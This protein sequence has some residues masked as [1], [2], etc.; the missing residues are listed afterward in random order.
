MITTKHPRAT[1]DTDHTVPKTRRAA[2]IECF[3]G[4][5][6]LTL[7]SVPVPEPGPGEVLIAGDTAGVGGWDADMRAGWSPGK[8]PSFPLILDSDG[9]GHV[10]AVGSRVRRFQI[11]DAVYAYSFDN[12]KGGFYAEYVAVVSSNV[13][14]GAAI[15][16]PARS[17]SDPDHRAHSYR[18][19]MMR[20]S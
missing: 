6:V 3:G 16:D 4:P 11:G 14:P 20:Y 19:S 5:E 7:I 18:A 9:S 12:P 17:W 13:A 15:S 8:A 10:A 1:L 2:V